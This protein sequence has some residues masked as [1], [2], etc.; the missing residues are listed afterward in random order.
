MSILVERSYIIKTVKAV[1]RSCECRNE[2]K[3][4]GNSKEIN[5][6]QREKQWKK[7]DVYIVYMFV[8]VRGEVSI[9][10]VVH[11][12]FYSSS[13]GLYAKEVVHQ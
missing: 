12:Y 11:E 4:T 13:I 5:S 8:G 7:R 1:L 10:I 6:V 2:Q 3:T 9:C